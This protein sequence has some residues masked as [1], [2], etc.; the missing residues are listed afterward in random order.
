MQATPRGS[1]L[2]AVPILL[3]ALC[4]AWGMDRYGKSQRSVRAAGP[5]VSGA[6][7]RVVVP[8][9]A[10][11]FKLWRKEHQRGRT[12]LFFGRAWPKV[13]PDA[14][15]EVPEVRNY[16]LP[17]SNYVTFL[18]ERVLD[19][20]TFLFLATETGIARRVVAVV[21]EPAFQAAQEANRTA[22]HQETVA[23]GLLVPYMGF[24]RIFT[25]LK[26]L[27]SPEEPVL[28]YVAADFFQGSSADELKRRLAEAGV[29]S[30]LI[31]LCEQAGDPEVSEGARRELARFA[32][33]LG[34]G[35]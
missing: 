27:S 2:I 17:L 34:A 29:L 22:K 26:G 3:A 20:S 31:V 16:P 12:V 33:L 15:L 32:M 28:V 23:E 6:V 25:T 11:A 10:E 18:E 24:P 19:R 4:A 1:L 9:P 13:Q 30:D 7:R 8:D 5:A 14:F 35:G 21:S